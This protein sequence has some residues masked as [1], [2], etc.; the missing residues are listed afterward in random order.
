M[1][2]TFSVAISAVFFLTSVGSWP[3]TAFAA[4]DFQV[5][6]NVTIEGDVITLHLTGPAEYT[7]FPLSEPEKLVVDLLN[8]EQDWKKRELNVNG[9]LVKRVRSG[10]FQNEPSKIARVVVD[11]SA[12]ADYSIQADGAEIVVTLTPKSGD[13]AALETPVAETAEAPPAEAAPAEAAPA[14]DAVPPDVPADIAATSESVQSPPLAQNTQVPTPP[15]RKKITRAKKVK[16][17]KKAEPKTRD[18]MATLSREPVTLDFQEAD[19][20]D[21]LRVLAAKAGVNMIYGTDVAGTLTI[22]LHKV[23][24]NECVNTILTLQGLVPQQVGESILRI[25]TPEALATE[26]SKAVT[27]TR[28]F[29]LNYATAAEVKAQLDAIRGAEGRKGNISI[30]NR[31]NGLVITDTPE[32]LDSAG[33]LII[34]LDEQPRQVLIDAKI[35]ELALTDT[36]DLGVQWEFANTIKNNGVNDR[37]TIGASQAVAAGTP[38]PG[39]LGATA[40]AGDLRTPLGLAGSGSFRGTGVNLPPGSAAGGISFGL[41]SDN[42][43]LQ[44]TLSA[45]ASK[46]LTKTLANPRIVTLNNEP[47]K[48]LLG[49]RIP[50][51]ITTVTPT[52]STQSTQFIEAGI[53]LLVTPTINVDHRI[54]LKVKPEVSSLVAILAAGPRI[55]T[56]EAETTVLVE[57]NETIV[58][59]GLIDERDENTTTQVPLM[60]DLPIIGT[61]FRSNKKDKSRSELLVFIT[62]KLVRQ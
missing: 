54:T 52:G 46:G 36:L 12:P 53:K 22:H 26:R 44:A 6:T 33:K 23:P 39:A 8:T 21:V 48:I 31:T 13:S 55:R 5:L 10:Q 27:F 30:D 24:F 20:R 1:K 19:I 62:P 38:A 7:A 43:L 14:A 56:R 16:P 58:I 47:A 42:S 3:S 11:L 40:V 2:K 41:V 60:G 57:N 35:V 34:Q 61:F 49:D 32:G 17:V 15:K 45:L 9:S 18:I 25:I 29:P 4:D 51:N 50:F 59:G 28:V 37:M